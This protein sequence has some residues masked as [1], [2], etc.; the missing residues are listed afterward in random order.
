MSAL[1][2]DVHATLLQLLSGLVSADNATRA[3]AEKSL[4]AEWSQRENVEMLL[5]FLAEQATAGENDTIRSFLAVLFRRIAIRMPRDPLVL[6]VTDRTIDLVSIPVKTELRKLLLTGFTAPQQNMVRHKLGDAIAEVA[7]ESGEQKKNNNNS[8]GADDWPELI[9][10]LFSL[11]TNP[12]DSSFRESAFRVFSLTPE[13]ISSQYFATALPVFNAGFEDDCDDVRIAACSAFVAF[14]QGLPKRHWNDMAPLLPNLL[15]SLPR[16]LQ[17]GQDSALAAVLESLIELVDLAPKLFKDMFPTIIGFCL[18]VATKKD[19][20]DGATR[21]AALELLTTFAEVSPAMCKRTPSYTESM[22]T[23]TLSMLTEVCIDDDDAAEWNNKDE[24]GVQDGDDEDDEPEYEAARQALD[25]V[26][27]KLGGQALAS[28]LF[29]YLPQMINSTDFRQ[30]QAALM[31]L[32]A[33]AEG[34]SDVLMSEIP[35]ILDMILPTLQDLHP[36]VQYACCNALGQM[37]TD[38]ADV[39]Q[40]TVGDRVLPALIGM[41]TNKFVPRVQTHAAAALVNF[42]ENASKEVLE[43]YLDL[44]LNNLLVLLNSPKRYVQEQV[45]T[46]IAIIADS[47]EKKFATYY[48]TLMPLLISVLRSEDASHKV[49]KAKCIECSTLIALAVGK[50]MFLPLSQELIQLFGYIQQTATEDDDLIKSYLEQGWGR[51]CRILE[52]DFLPYLPLVL[53]PLLISAKATQDISLLDEEEVEEFDN[54]PEWDVI[55]LSG[56]MIAVHTASLDDKQL[57]MDLLRTYAIQ[58]KGDFQPWV[59]EIVETIAI[60]ALDFYLHDG[61]RGSAALTLAALLRCS[62][63]ATGAQSNETVSLWTQICNKLMEVLAAEPVAEVL[64]ANYTSLV[65]CVAAL[66]S[67]PA[68][69]TQDQLEQ[70]SECINTN[71]TEIYSRIKSRDNED[72]E[73]TEDV[74]EEED[75]YTDEELLDEINKAVSAIAKNTK[76]AFLVVFSTLAPTVATFIQDENTNVKLCGL[77]II[78]DVLERTAEELGAYHDM[79]V[80]AIGE[81]L[82]SSHAGVRQAAFFAVGIAAQHGGETYRS[83]CLSCLE[84]MFKM[85]QVPDARA[86]ENILATENAVSAIAKVC[87]SY[88]A[89]IPGLDAVLQQWVTLLP[90]VQDEEAAPFAYS[91][92]AELVKNNHPAV[93]SQLPKVVDSVVQALTHA[94]IAGATAERTVAAVKQALGTIPQADAVALMGKYPADVQ[95][96][97]QKWFA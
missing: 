44:L 28:P 90:V 82:S 50:E 86:E 52:L 64:V 89:D 66:G 20:V 41:L 68:F 97:I 54:N 42:S 62:V 36:R 22:V 95:I 19:E 53:P 26:A 49:L 25:R 34:C 3:A 71:L 10:I 75:E 35:R 67:T 46:T 13:L 57:A 33:A 5:I 92:L 65:E 16:F 96:V 18:Q 83:F 4:E 80:A 73:Y 81:S 29:Q 23:N 15:N 17:N 72:D 2:P 74:D 21:M 48:D 78:C 59:R 91:F 58:L 1:Q 69:T 27:L 8:G 51:I 84:P 11:A 56:K 43:P 60:P 30:R 24:D 93:V 38:F 88:G 14:F 32:S 94:S 61:V 9:P 47:A 79:F 70:M 40:R 12:N 55:S 87:R 6:L 45:L 7:R 37:S 39:M 63:I 85:T 77:C 76:Q 31:A